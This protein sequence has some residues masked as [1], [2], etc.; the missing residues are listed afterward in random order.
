MCIRDRKEVT[1]VNAKT[2][3]LIATL[4]CGLQ[5]A[6]ALFQVSKMLNDKEKESFSLKMALETIK[7]KNVGNGNAGILTGTIGI[8][9]LYN[10][11]YQQTLID[12]FKTAALYWI[13]ESYQ[14]KIVQY[15]ID[16][17]LL[18]GLTGVGLVLISAMADFKPDWDS[19]LLL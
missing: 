2:E 1:V 7:Q 11:F 19:C 3:E 12:A 14:Q 18:D 8:A 4:N 5:N 17:S 9:L 13:C 6:Y 10:H 16:V 15:E